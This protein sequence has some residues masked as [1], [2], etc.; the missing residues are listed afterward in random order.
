MISVCSARS[1]AGTERSSP[2]L[3]RGAKDIVLGLRKGDSARFFGARAGQ[4]SRY[5]IPDL[6]LGERGW[7]GVGDV[8]PGD[9]TSYIISHFHSQRHRNSVV[10]QE[11]VGCVG[12]SG[13]L[14]GEQGSWNDQ[15]GNSI[16]APSEGSDGLQTGDPL[17]IEQDINSHER[18]RL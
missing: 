6:H 8:L 7:K 15:A 1:N 5:L 2:R 9:L 3:V 16:A 4:F 10:E 18:R 14:A 13:K 12:K 17:G 11:R